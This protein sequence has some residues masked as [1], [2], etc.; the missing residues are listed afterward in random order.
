VQ[1]SYTRQEPIPSDSFLRDDEENLH[2]DSIVKNFTSNNGLNTQ[3]LPAIESFGEGIFFEFGDDK[4][5]TW[6][7]KYPKI[8][9]RTSI[10][11]GNNDNLE[12][13]FYSNLKLTPK[14]ILLH[15]F[16]HLIIKELEYLAGYPA[17]SI[18]ER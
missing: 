9:E 8:E 16:S 1:T 14:Y 12:S 13:N 15:T 2:P 5:N 18:R 7:Q 4:L 3:F 17:T 6:I 10:I 11:I